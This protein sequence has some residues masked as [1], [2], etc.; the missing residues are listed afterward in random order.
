MA[1]VLSALVALRTRTPALRWPGRRA[2]RLGSLA[3]LLLRS[4]D[5][6]SARPHET[7][8]QPDQ[9]RALSDR[10]RPVVLSRFGWSRPAPGTGDPRAATAWRME[11]CFDRRG[12]TEGESCPV[13]S[14]YLLPE[15]PFDGIAVHLLGAAAPRHHPSSDLHRR[16]AIDEEQSLSRWGCHHQGRM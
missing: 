14:V 4:A 16:L 11:F 10:S 15:V 13:W 2:R 12:Q 3:S 8:L 1:D 5:C 9:G 7:A 6:P